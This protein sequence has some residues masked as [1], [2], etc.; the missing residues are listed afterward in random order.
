[1]EGKISHVPADP[2]AQVLDPVGAGDGF[3]AG[4]LAGWLRGFTLADSLRLGARVGAAA[5]GVFGDYHGY[6]RAE[7]IGL[8]RGSV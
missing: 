7:E 4:F 1:M 2:V 8:L 6:P 3:D 5:V